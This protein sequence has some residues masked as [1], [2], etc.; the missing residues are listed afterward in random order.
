MLGQVDDVI[1]GMARRLEPRSGDEP[2]VN[3]VD[4]VAVYVDVAP[5]RGRCLGPGQ[6][7]PSIQR[8]ADGGNPWPSAREAVDGSRR[9]S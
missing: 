4:E 5:L 1:G 7:S 2:T 6:G 8:A 9:E 3:A